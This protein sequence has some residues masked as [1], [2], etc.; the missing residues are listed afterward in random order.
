MV[1]VTRSIEQESLREIRLVLPIKLVNQTRRRREPQSRAPIACISNG[2]S[3]RFIPPRVIQIEMK[4]AAGQRITGA[5]PERPE[6]RPP[7]QHAGF[8]RLPCSLDCAGAL[9]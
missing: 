6:H 8:P 4:S 5:R 9:H 7:W 2:Q 1:E 3:E